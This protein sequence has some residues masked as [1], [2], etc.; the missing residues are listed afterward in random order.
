MSVF[1]PKDTDV[2]TIDLSEHDK[3][4][5]AEAIEDFAKWVAEVEKVDD[6]TKENTI[7]RWIEDFEKWLK[8][9]KKND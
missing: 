1:I 5:R 2:L 7:K 3:Q 6:A 9:R 8:G 4:I